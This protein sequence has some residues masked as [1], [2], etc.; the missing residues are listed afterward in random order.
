MDSV[1]LRA[2]DDCVLAALAEKRMPGCVVL[3]GRRGKIV[4]QQAYGDRQVEPIRVPM[5][6]DTVFDLASLTKP[7]A[8]ATSVMILA[9]Q[10]KL[11]LDDAVSRHIAEFAAEGKQSITVRQLLTHQAGLVPDNPL[12]DYFHGVDRAWERILALRPHVEPGTRFVYSDVGFLV[13]G[14]LVRQVSG[15]SIGEFSGQHIFQPLGMSETCFLPGA[16]LRPRAAVTEQR[17]GKWLQGEVHDPRAFNLGGV[18]GHAGLFSTAEDLAVY[19]QMMLGRGQY[20]GVQILSEQTWS[21]MTGPVQVSSGLRGLG[22]DIQ[23]SYSSNRGQS[24]SPAAFGHGGFTG[25]ALWI[26]PQ[27]EL[28][29]IFLSNRLHPDGKGSVNLLAGKI[30]S[31]AADAIQHK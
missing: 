14:E 25:T 1:R 30:G 2:I 19:A 15:Q 27:L 12:R 22:W 24:F 13:L 29:V 8:T 4:F 11:S 16:H 26:D 23:S 9:E 5:T 20:A 3:I 7:I 18:A 10:G 6:F 21:S 17:D 31:I 28:F